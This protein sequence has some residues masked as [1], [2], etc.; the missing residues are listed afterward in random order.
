MNQCTMKETSHQQKLMGRLS[1]GNLGNTQILSTWSLSTCN[2]RRQYLNQWSS[3]SIFRS[4]NGAT[5]RQCFLVDV[6]EAGLYSKTLSGLLSTKGSGPSREEEFVAG[7]GEFMR[8]CCGMDEISWETIWLPL[9]RCCTH[10][11]TFWW[12]IHFLRVLDVEVVV[13]SG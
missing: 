4:N 2:L 13:C 9:L 10:Q 8:C 12:L 1:W 7:Q 6:H 5:I 3:N 11:R